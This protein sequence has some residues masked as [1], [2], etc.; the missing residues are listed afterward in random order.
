[1]LNRHLVQLLNH[2][3]AD[4]IRHYDCKNSSIWVHRSD[5]HTFDAVAQGNTSCM[6]QCKQVLLQCKQIVIRV[7][8]FVTKINRNH[9]L[10]CSAKREFNS[11]N[12]L[13]INVKAD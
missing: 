5:V 11:N 8:K 2:C 3:V 4:V 1:M 13:I 10:N 6:Y 12:N 7:L 9:T